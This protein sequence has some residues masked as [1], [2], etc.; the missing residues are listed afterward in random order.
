[1]VR[2][3]LKSSCR[4]SVARKIRKN[5]KERPRRSR[6]Q[7]TAISFS[8]VRKSRPECKK[9]LKKRFN[10]PSRRSKSQKTKKRK[11]KPL[12]FGIYPTPRS[13]TG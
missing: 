9:V 2:H 5:I 13:L 4:S 8:Q 11:S 10:N 12:T 3:T 7:N 6:R 1:M